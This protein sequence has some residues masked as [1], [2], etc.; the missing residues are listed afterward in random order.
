VTIPF[1]IEEWSWLFSKCSP[2][3]MSHQSCELHQPQNQAQQS[4]ERRNRFVRDRMSIHAQDA[5]QLSPGKRGTE[6]PYGRAVGTKGVVNVN[7]HT[8][9]GVMKWLGYRTLLAHDPS[10]GSGASSIWRNQARWIM[11]SRSGPV[12]MYLICGTLATAGLDSMCAHV[13]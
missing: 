8:L 1:S 12:P 2:D 9:L 5:S 3:T 11:A 13:P 6:G 7:T 4:P 10:Q